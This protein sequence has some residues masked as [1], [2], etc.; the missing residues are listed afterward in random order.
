MKTDK[1]R[2][3]FDD[4]KYPFLNVKIDGENQ[5]EIKERKAQAMAEAIVFA[6]ELKRKYGKPKE[7]SDVFY[8][9]D[10]AVVE[11][12]KG[13]KITQRCP[14]CGGEIICIENGNSYEVKCN[15]GGC[16]SEGYRGI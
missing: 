14:I 1:V 2:G 15:D 11:Y 12:F 9:I 10:A 4:Y 13:E 16:I 7:H 5:Q 6:A 3:E 8:A